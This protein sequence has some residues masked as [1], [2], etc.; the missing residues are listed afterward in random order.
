M[1]RNSG[2]VDAEALKERNRMDSIRPSIQKSDGKQRSGKGF[3]LEEL[4]TAGL[5][6]PAAKKMKIPVDKRRKTS[7]DTN[8]AELKAFNEKQQ[9]KTKP[10]PTAKQKV[11]EQTKKKPKK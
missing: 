10:K 2:Q 11:Q 9:A 1:L 7:H 5:D 4:K 8:V 3:S 6:Q